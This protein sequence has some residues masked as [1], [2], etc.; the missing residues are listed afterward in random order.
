MDDFKLFCRLWMVILTLCIQNQINLVTALNLCSYGT[1]IV[2]IDQKK[3]IC[4][5]GVYNR[6]DQHGLQQECCGI[7]DG[8]G[9]VVKLQLYAQQKQICCDGELHD[10]PKHYRRHSRDP[11]CCGVDVIFNPESSF[12]CNNQI[13]QRSEQFAYCDDRYGLEVAVGRDQVACKLW[14]PNGTLHRVYQWQP[15]Y[16]CCGLNLSNTNSHFCLR[17][18]IWPNGAVVSK[19][20]MEIYDEN[21]YIC[22]EDTSKLI[23]KPGPDKFKAKYWGIETDLACLNGK[24]VNRDLEQ[25][26]ENNNKKHVIPNNFLPC[27]DDYFDPYNKRTQVDCCNGVVNHARP[28]MNITCCG[29]EFIDTDLYRCCNNV[30]IGA[31]K[32][33]C[34]NRIYEGTSGLVCC[35]TKL[36]NSSYL[37][38]EPKSSIRIPVKKKPGHNRCCGKQTFYYDPNG[39][40]ECCGGKIIK[41]EHNQVCENDIVTFSPEDSEEVTKQI[42]KSLEKSGGCGFE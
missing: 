35:G 16:E 22:C 30:K 17:G 29:T 21:K 36:I 27:G 18:K 33:C 9:S 19:C 31:S 40:D 20:G 2:M 26:V 3:H 7:K 42:N 8:N 15:G 4:C 32:L 23:P 11:K 25:I 38:C 39:K 24:V 12:C 6:K 13:Y 10:L 1:R 5:G 41:L 34:G 28:G 37:C 14:T